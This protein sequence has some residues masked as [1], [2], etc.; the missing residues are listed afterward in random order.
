MSSEVAREAHLATYVTLTRFAVVLFFIAA[1]LAHTW[2]LALLLL[3]VAA[4]SD[5][6]DGFLLARALQ[7]VTE[8]GTIPPTPLQISCF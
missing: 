6:L 4:I 8:L 2:W 1:L 5:F 7:Q 3:G